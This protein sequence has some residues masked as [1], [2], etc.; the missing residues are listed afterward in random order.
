LY[1]F[2]PNRPDFK[3]FSLSFRFVEYQ[4]HVFPDSIW[5]VGTKAGIFS[6]ESYRV[7]TAIEH[8]TIYR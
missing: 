4:G 3:K 7:E 1:L 2:Y 8:L 5:E 6:T